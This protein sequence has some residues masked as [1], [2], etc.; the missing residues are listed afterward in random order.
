MSKGITRRWLTNS[1]GVILL[2][3][4][5]IIIV[6]FFAVKSYYYTSISEA[7]SGRSKELVNVMGHVSTSEQ[8]MSSVIDYIENFPE[9]ELMEVMVYD[10]KGSIVITSTGFAPDTSQPTPDYTKAVKN[11]LTSANWK[12]KLNSGE[13]A[14]SVT[15]VIY[16]RYGEN[17]GAV[18]YLVSLEPANRQIFL[19][20]IVCILGGIICLFL[21]ILSGTYFIKSILTPLNNL[22]LTAKKIAQGDFKIKIEK[23]YDDEIGELT[24]AINNM[25][26]ELGTSE[27]MKN[28]F[29]SSVSHE[30]RT[31]LTAIKGWAET[32]QC[33][34]YDKDTMEKGINTI[35]NET[36]RLV[37]IVEEL[38]DFSRI[39]SGRMVL[40]MD[41]MDILAELDDA[42]YM[43]KER[44]VSEKKHL[45][46]DEPEM[47]SPVIGD[48]NRI[49]QVFINIIDNAL[50]YT[51]SDGVVTVNVYEKNGFIIIIIADNG[52]G[53]SERDLPK[54]KEKFYKANNT[55]RGSGIGLAVADEIIHLHNGTL[56]ITSEENVGTTV[57]IS[58]PVLD[59]SES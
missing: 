55:Q 32:M 50:K 59:T 31:P 3:I 40:S 17:V 15:R 28:D 37:G 25:A 39:Q 36:E 45:V 18:R 19:W 7:I 53:I 30:L 6:A 9:K 26:A 16:N 51:P 4:F 23:Q 8:F 20:L 38:L 1:L 48:K 13:Y 43:Q 57:T 58:I 27:K 5:V 24:D 41:K 47:V 29:I 49:R 2:F 21:F 52:C 56:D 12:G 22:S 35:K 34:E 33:M 11:N 46:F 44:A 42:I 54:V 14:M 10:E